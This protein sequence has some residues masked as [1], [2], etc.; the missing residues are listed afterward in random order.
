MQSLLFFALY[1]L[2]PV[3]SGLLVTRYLGPVLGKMLTD[4]CGTRDRADFWVRIC[5]VMLM[6]LPL[7]LVLLTAPMRTCTAEAVECSVSVMRRASFFT[8]IGLLVGVWIIASVVRRF[9]PK[10]VANPPKDAPKALPKA[11]SVENAVPVPMSQR[12]QP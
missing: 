10:P 2:I 6:A 4:L 9:V 1:L 5:M 11:P 12:A 7:V 3:A 8:V